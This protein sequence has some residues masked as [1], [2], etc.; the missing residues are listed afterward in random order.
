LLNNSF[1]DGRSCSPDVGRDQET[2]MFTDDFYG[3]G[4]KPCSAQVIDR[5]CRDMYEVINTDQNQFAA[6]TRDFRRVYGKR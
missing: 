4:A 1:H 6:C 3:K 5:C 2:G